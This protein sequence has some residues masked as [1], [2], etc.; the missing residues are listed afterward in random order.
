MLSAFS[1]TASA[2]TTSGECS[3]TSTW[4]NDSAT[5]TLTV[6][7]TGFA[8]NRS[9]AWEYFT[10]ENVVIEKVI[11][12]N[13]KKSINIK[14]AAFRNCPNLEYLVMGPNIWYVNEYAFY[15]CTNLKNVY[16]NG[17]TSDMTKELTIYTSD[18]KNVQP[19][20]DCTDTAI[21]V[22]LDNVGANPC[23]PI[24]IADENGKISKLPPPHKR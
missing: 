17:T 18:D 12:E 11:I 10:I 8:S 5:K 15:G 1:L 22:L 4:T 19:K 14:N 2:Q 24:L 20:F 6:S 13:D 23:E 9:S 3:Q 16:I 21:M 7:G